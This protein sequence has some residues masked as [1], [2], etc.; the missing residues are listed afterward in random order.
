M[1]S[2]VIRIKERSLYAECEVHVL[3]EGYITVKMIYCRRCTYDE[4]SCILIVL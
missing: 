4:P 1:A 2:M 3:Y